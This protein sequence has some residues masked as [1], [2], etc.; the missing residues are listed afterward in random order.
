MSV[1]IVVECGKNW[2]VNKEMSVT[3]AFEEAKLLVKSAQ[4]CG[5]DS[6]KWQCHV[7]EDEIKK[8][9]SDRHDWIRLN[10]QLTPLEDFWIPLE[11]YHR[12]IGIHFLVT[13][14]SKMAAEKINPLVGAW[15][16][17]SPDVLDVELLEY[18]KSTQK[19]VILSSGM[20]TKEQRQTARDI[21]GDFITMQCVSEYPLPLEHSNLWELSGSEFNGLSDHTTSL[22]TGA[23]ATVLGAEM[24]EKHFMV[25]E[26]CID[27]KVSLMPN[28][29]VEYIQNIRD[30]EKTMIENERP[31]KREKESLKQF[32]V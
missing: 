9:H 20:T 16:L 7:A 26:R 17:A 1:E 10:E 12:E 30:A 11:N 18:L 3:D 29:L 28:Q 13:P 6:C 21:V 2:L 27:A 4:N 14:M 8:R 23:L 31:T 15:K 5:A 22:I 19:A 25:D 32:V 24:I